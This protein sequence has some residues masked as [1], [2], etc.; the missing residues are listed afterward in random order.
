MITNSA[1]FALIQPRIRA[2]LKSRDDRVRLDSR[3][4]LLYRTD[5]DFE[6]DAL[7]FRSLRLQSIC[8]TAFPK[9]TALFRLQEAARWRSCSAPTGASKTVRMVVVYNYIRRCRQQR[10]ARIALSRVPAIPPMFATVT[11]FPP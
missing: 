6:H 3:I 11:I 8:Q 9:R 4:A 1:Y 7:N 10:R 2:L 5:D